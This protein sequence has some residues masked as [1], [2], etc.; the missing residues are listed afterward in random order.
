MMAFIHS[1]DDEIITPRRGLFFMRGGGDLWDVSFI[2]WVW[3]G[4]AFGHPEHGML[5][6]R[7]WVRVVFYRARFFARRPRRWRWPWMW[8]TD[9]LRLSDMREIIM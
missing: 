4:R 8:G 9:T 3:S 5:R 6:R 2:W 1:I 7:K